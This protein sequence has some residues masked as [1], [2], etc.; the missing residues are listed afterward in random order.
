MP[1]TIFKIR[2]DHYEFLVMSFSLTNA[3]GVFMELM[4]RVF[5]ECLDMFVISFIDD[6]LVYSKLDKKTP[7]T[8]SKS[9]NHFERDQVVHQILQM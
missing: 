2:Y 6:I 1:R 3:L 4:N 9:P 5:K 7:M 8:P